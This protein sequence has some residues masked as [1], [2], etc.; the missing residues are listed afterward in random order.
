M[1]VKVDQ[2][3]GA[4]LGADLLGCAGDGVVVTFPNFCCDGVSG[5]GFLR[6]AI[7]VEFGAVE[8]ADDQVDAF[9]EAFVEG[10]RA[11]S[12]EFLGVG[13]KGED[14]GF[15]VRNEV[16]SLSSSVGGGEDDGKFP[17][18]DVEEACDF[19]R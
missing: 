16:G 10:F 19:P 9:A 18:F 7:A 5:G 1:S 15:A 8:F 13:V 14:S 6:F 2:D 17:R 4:V 11:G 3:T 12:R